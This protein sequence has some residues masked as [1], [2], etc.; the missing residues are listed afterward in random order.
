MAE[1]PT[2]ARIQ[3]H[4]GVS[5]RIRELLNHLGADGTIRLL[6]VS[7]KLREHLE[8]SGKMQVHEYCMEEQL[9]EHL[10]ASGTF[11]NISEFLDASGASGNIASFWRHLQLL[12]A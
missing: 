4:I 1:K 5:Y 9:Q 12:I 2:P 6:D 10:E 8:S 7:G 11:W 3:E